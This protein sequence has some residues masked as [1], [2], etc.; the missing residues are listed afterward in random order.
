MGDHHDCLVEFLTC[1]L[2]KIDDFVAGP[3][4]KISCGLIAE[5]ESRF[6]NESPC[7]SDSLLLPAGEMAGI[8]GKLAVQFQKMHDLL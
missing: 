6:G 8:V 5:Q 2:Q 1:H 3:T 7:D 4:V